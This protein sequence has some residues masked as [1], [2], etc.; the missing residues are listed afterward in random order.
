MSEVEQQNDGTSAKA[1][2][3]AKLSERTAPRRKP[4][5]QAEPGHCPRLLN[6]SRG[7]PEAPDT[8]SM[9]PGATQEGQPGKAEPGE[10]GLPRDFGGYVLLERL[11]SGGMGDVY[12]AE[13]RHMERVVAVK[14]LPPKTL[15]SPEAVERFH[16]EV[17]AAARLSHPHVVTA[18][19]AG[20]VDGV[21]FLAMEFIDGANLHSLVNSA[22][23]L[24][25]P[26][27]VNYIIQAARGL[28]FAHRKKVIHRDVKPANLLLDREGTIKVLD[29]GLARL[30]TP[31]ATAGPSGSG[32][33]TQSGQIM[34]TI[35]YM[36][37]E[38]ALDSKHCRK[39][40]D[41]YSLGCTLYFLLTGR[42][43][44]PADT[45][46]ERIIAHR[47][48]PIPSLCDARSDVPQSLNAIFQ[49]MVAKRPEERQASMT[50]VIVQLAACLPVEQREAGPWPYP[51]TGVGGVAKAVSQAAPEAATLMR[52]DDPS[53]SKGQ[54][55]EATSDW[56]TQPRTQAKRAPHVLLVGT[57]AAG[58]VAVAAAVVLVKSRGTTELPGQLGPIAPPPASATR[59][60]PPPPL[61]IS[62]FPFDEARTHQE[63]WARYLGVRVEYE[64]SLG[65]KMVLIPPGE[66][67]MGN[68]EEQIAM[69]L[70]ELEEKKE[71][72]ET[73]SKR[74]RADGPQHKVRIAAP[75]RLAAHEVTVGQFNAFVDAT[76]YKTEAERD[77]RGGM[78]MVE[79]GG[80]RKWEQRP[81][82]TWRDVGV[83]QTDQLPV[84]NVSWNDAAAFCRWLSE[85]EGATYRLPTETQWEYA[86]RSGTT[87]RW[88]FGENPTDHRH[89]AWFGFDMHQ[90]VG[91]KMPNP[92]G[93][94]D[95]YGNVREWCSDWYLE[96]FYRVS[97]TEDPQGPPAGDYPVVRGGAYC[98]VP[99][100]ATSASR[101]WY[102]PRDRSLYDGFR[103]A[104]TFD[105]SGS[106]NP[107][108]TQV[109]PREP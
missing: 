4:D 76:G 21:Q 77:G 5:G 79:P 95:M 29:L 108:R 49:R 40:A 69:S 52:A 90:P 38:Q 102:G 13:H 78:G 100:E 71:L 18:Y 14:M 2:A 53:L 34:G 89:F 104:S 85:E 36:S 54:P 25:V 32:S 103:V 28:E 105:H 57:F 72:N 75:F 62:P 1:I 88:F 91:K 24:S 7:Q 66:F 97:P 42:I 45:P 8:V 87:T 80:A 98:F 67:M 74:I 22:G 20:E 63:R 17:K 37:P 47:E 70:K 11:G 41:I 26:Q 23:P 60:G 73:R 16:R 10:T 27:A 33:L 55:C 96:S 86:C 44:Y 59:P 19:D 65:M 84:V 43:P 31:L 109:G 106:R 93:I 50:E 12:R 15:D 6:E 94:F 48:R 82:F 46:M 30:E 58:L 81:E 101:D 92:F 51:S 64:N 83:E 35:D 39:S 56:P 107:N 68:S 61:A 3:P 99:E 9:G